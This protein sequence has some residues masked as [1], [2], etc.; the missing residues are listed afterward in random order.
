MSARSVIQSS[1]RSVKW[2]DILLLGRQAVAWWLDELEQMLPT[3]LR[4]LLLSSRNP[5]LLLELSRSTARFY[6]NNDSVFTDVAA[7]AEAIRATVQALTSQAAKV[8][9]VT[10][11]VVALDTSL[12]L[13]RGIVLPIAATSTLSMIIRHQLPKLV[14]M[15]ADD[16]VAIHEIVSRQASTKTMQVD[17]TL[18]KRSTLTWIQDLARGAG[19][20]VQRIVVD[21]RN[22]QGQKARSVLWS[23]SDTFSLRTV[24]IVFRH[25]VAIGLLT[26]ILL[27]SA[28]HGIRVHVLDHRLLAEVADLQHQATDVIALNDRL[29]RGREQIVFLTDRAEAVSAAEVLARLTTLLPSDVSLTQFT[30]QT[31]AVTCLGKARHAASLINIIESSDVFNEPHFISATT[32]SSDGDGETFE[33]AFSVRQVP[34]NE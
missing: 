20:K 24:E 3:R 8:G 30:Y 17:I 1:S 11:V 21:R 32:P 12:T 14:P 22:A 6:S 31:G 13:S 18:V 28:L 25:R 4:S 16:I 34:T 2:R 33:L 23:P 26:L 29:R 9:A 5:S 19:L 15:A 10:Q 27:A 7:E